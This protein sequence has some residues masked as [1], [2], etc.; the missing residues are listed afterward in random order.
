MRSVERFMDKYFIW[1]IFG[2]FFFAGVL[3]YAAVAVEDVGDTDFLLQMVNAARDLGGVKWG[4][5]V[6]IIFLIII[7]TIKASKLRPFWDRI[8]S[9]KV[10]VAPILA[11]IVGIVTLNLDPKDHNSWAVLA[12][13]AFAG[14]GSIILHQLLDAIKELPF[15]G[16]KYDQIIDLFAN[17]LGSKTVTTKPKKK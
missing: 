8:G 11:V 7:S 14:G 13:W 10:L 2:C 9:L 4:V 5:A 16:P 6:T 17:L 15:V 12:A 1:I 3:S